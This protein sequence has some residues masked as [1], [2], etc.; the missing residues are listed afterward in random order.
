MTP[1]LT[2]I[3]SCIAYKSSYDLRE[4]H[5]NLK[6]PIV[7]SPFPGCFLT[8]HKYIYK[9]QLTHDVRLGLDSQN[10]NYKKPLF[11]IKENIEELKAARHIIS[12]LSSFQIKITFEIGTEMRED[13]ESESEI[14]TINKNTVFKNDE[15]I[16]CLENKNNVLFC[17]CG[18]LCLCE[19]C[20]LRT[21]RSK[22]CLVCKTINTIIRNYRIKIFFPITR[23][24]IFLFTSLT[25]PE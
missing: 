17:N 1:L 15:C 4:L 5:L 11:I 22:K 19:Q 14:E 9:I 3:F 2:Y 7:E 13:N 6:F 10:Y 8:L 21:K 12:F 20:F 16:I 25:L 18:H 24:K 23:G